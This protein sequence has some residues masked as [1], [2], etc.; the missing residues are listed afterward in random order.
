M[1]NAS[2]LA[3]NVGRYLPAQRTVIETQN[4]S[5]GQGALQIQPGA[6]FSRWGDL[7]HKQHVDCPTLLQR[8]QTGMISNWTA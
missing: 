2:T 4:K 3:E 5:L 6:G 1:H 7:N 8:E